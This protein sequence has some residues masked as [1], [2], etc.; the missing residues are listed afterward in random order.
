MSKRCFA[1]LTR[2]H[3]FAYN[4]LRAGARGGLVHPMPFPLPWL[5]RAMHSSAEGREGVAVHADV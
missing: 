5:V 1:I 3:Q 2:K 4:A